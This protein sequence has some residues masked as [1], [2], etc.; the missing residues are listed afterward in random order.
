[1]PTS[2]P[3]RSLLAAFLLLATLPA[4]S[5]P[6][7]TDK[8][9]VGLYAK[10]DMSGEPVAVLESGTPLEVLNEQDDA[11][12]V[13][14]PD[15]KSGWME[16]GYVTEEKPAGVQLL[17][18]GE[19]RRSL[20]QELETLRGDM[21]VAMDQSEE[22]DEGD[23]KQRVAQLSAA[24]RDLSGR[25]EAV[26]MAL[27]GRTLAVETVQAAEPEGIDRIPALW[28]VIL[29]AITLVLGFA[30]GLVW[31]DRRVRS[32]HGGFRL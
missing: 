31:V 17:E 9:L 21:Q 20:Q 23:L 30:L 18:L 15:G 6:Y 11:L 25:L 22:T 12:E 1:M 7:V 5:G 26:R 2:T 29:A 3:L 28:F 14:A 27:D 32:R 4:S 13:R 16:A 24:N 19:E 10:P 8:L